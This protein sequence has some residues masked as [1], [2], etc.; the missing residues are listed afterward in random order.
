MSPEELPLRRRG[1]EYWGVLVQRRWIVLASLAVVVAT[2][3]IATPIHIH[4]LPRIGCGPKSV[5]N[6]PTEATKATSTAE[7]ISSPDVR[8]KKTFPAD[9]K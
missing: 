2:T 8:P 6:Q 1:L 5:P 7:P 4:H 9:A 3:G